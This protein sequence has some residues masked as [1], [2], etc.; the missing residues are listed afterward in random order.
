MKLI[1]NI[2][3]IILLIQSSILNADPVKNN[4][5]KIDIETIKFIEN[6]NFYTLVISATYD[7]YDCVSGLISKSKFLNSMDVRS[8]AID[9]TRNKGSSNSINYEKIVK[10]K[11]AEGNYKFIILFDEVGLFSDEFVEHLKST[12]TKNVITIGHNEINNIYL[13]PNFNNFFQMLKLIDKQSSYDV[14]YIHNA[15]S[16]MDRLF[17]NLLKNVSSASLSV[18]DVTAI[19]ESEITNLINR[20][21]T[22]SN[23]V[24]ISNL[25]YI[26]DDVSGSLLRDSEISKIFKKINK[27]TT[28]II[29]H[30]PC[31][32]FD[33]NSFSLSW[34]LNQLTDMIDTF[35][36]N[37]RNNIP[38]TN[39]IL[40]TQLNLNL[41]LNASILGTI[42]TND[43]YDILDSVDNVIYGHE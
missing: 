26:I 23:N 14:Y 27:P 9:I 17:L 15:N 41:I 7:Y 37:T 16:S 33:Q 3:I 38:I 40:S 30:G 34:Q 2:L 11:I 18:N 4:S 25:H 8:L 32:H 39:Y 22:S 43:L 31:N 36:F 35:I 29:S 19:Y 10:E 42:T 1:F 13:I 6:F 5:R 21:K 12:P 28:L 24:I 20:L